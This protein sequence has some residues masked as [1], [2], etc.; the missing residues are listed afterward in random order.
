MQIAIESTDAK[1]ET[2]AGKLTRTTFKNLMEHEANQ[3]IDA[4]IREFPN[5][6]DGR[7]GFETYNRQEGERVRKFLDRCKIDAEDCIGAFHIEAHAEL[8][9]S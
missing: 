1:T 2:V 9:H 8:D 4:I 3:I 5:I 6:L 7:D